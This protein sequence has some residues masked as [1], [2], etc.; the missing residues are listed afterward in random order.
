MTH[1][2]K[3]MS[4]VGEISRIIVFAGVLAGVHN[5]FSSKSI[6]FI[7]AVAHNVTVSDSELFARGPISPADSGQNQGGK[8]DVRVIAPLHDKALA[9]ADS[10]VVDSARSSAEQVYRIISITQLNQLLSAGHMLLIDARDSAAYRK[11]RIDGARNI[12]GLAA[13]EHFAELAPMPRDTLVVIYCNNPECHLGR[14]LA[15]FMGAIG[16]KRLYLYD[17]GFDGWEK[18]K[19]PVDSASPGR[20]KSP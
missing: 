6:P 10:G 12:F 16:F 15:E 1:S 3:L 8:R 20:L 19:M 2:S 7:R 5:F 13:D 18:A 9:R 17:D 4:L 14:M 11:G